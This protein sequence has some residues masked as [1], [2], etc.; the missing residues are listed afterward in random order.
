MRQQDVLDVLRIEAHLADVV[1]DGVDI[2][3]LRR[4]NQDQ[5]C[6]RGNEP[7]RDSARPDVVQVV[8][9]LERRNL[10]VLDVPRLA[11]AV[12]LAQ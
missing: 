9:H 5:P 4:V 3:L 1:D 6:A 7:H 10:L 12:T 2:R 8:H 11:A